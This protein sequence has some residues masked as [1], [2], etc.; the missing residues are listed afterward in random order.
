M[1][2]ITRPDEFLYARCTNPQPCLG[3]I[4]VSRN[5]LPLSQSRYGPLLDLRC[6]LCGYRFLVQVRH[7]REYQGPEH[8]F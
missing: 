4:P 6:P 8:A 7:L 2:E 3:G 1:A 5:A